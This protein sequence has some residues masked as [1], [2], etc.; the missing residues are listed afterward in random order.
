MKQSNLLSIIYAFFLLLSGTPVLAQN[1]PQP[2]RPPLEP[3]PEPDILPPSEEL[4]PPLEA[5]NGESQDPGLVIPGTIVVRQFEVFGSTVFSQSQLTELL[6]PYTNRPISFAELIQAQEV[7]N[8]LYID[9][10]YITTGTVISPQ[11]LKDGIVKIEV[12]EGSVEKIE[13]KGLKR[14]PNS[15]ITSR[16]KKATQAPLNQQQLLEALQLLQLNSL[17][18]RLSAEL[19]A[20][21]SPG[22]SILTV[23]VIQASV[24]STSLRLDNHRVPSVGQAATKFN[25][26]T[27]K[28][29]GCLR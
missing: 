6:E 14:L 23:E 18:D 21:T 10:G 4:L 3:L 19:S 13:V 8:Q 28:F 15:Y 25:L 26:H 5:P 12:I 20:G 2:V 24:F 11:T 27:K 1:V 17:V 22:S 29:T 16:L 9:Q 7:I